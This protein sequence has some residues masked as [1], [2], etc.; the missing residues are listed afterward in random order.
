MIDKVDQP[1]WKIIL[2]FKIIL[3][4]MIHWVS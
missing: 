1:D 4:F 2:R 3:V